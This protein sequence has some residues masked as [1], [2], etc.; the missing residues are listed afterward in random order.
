MTLEL[1]P[2]RSCNQCGAEPGERH[3]DWDDIALCRSTG[4]QLIQCEGEIHLFKGREYGE[5]EGECGPDIWDGRYPGITECHQLGLFTRPDSIWGESE[6]LNALSRLMS[7]G[8]VIWDK[9]V[10]KWV[11]A[12]GEDTVV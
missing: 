8:K 3:R 2:L 5:H 11:V 10:E 1:P 6:D 12:R 9:N 4:H 7:L